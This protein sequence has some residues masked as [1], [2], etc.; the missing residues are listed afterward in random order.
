MAFGFQAALAGG[1]GFGF[2][3]RTG[4]AVTLEAVNDATVLVLSGEAIDEPVVMHGPFVMNTADEIRQ[5]MADFQS[6]RF[7]AITAEP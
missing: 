5:A 2:L 6:G 7:G 1:S 4:G 3:D